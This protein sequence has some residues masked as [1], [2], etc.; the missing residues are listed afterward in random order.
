MPTVVRGEAVE[1]EPEAEH[2]E[3]DANE[4]EASASPRV[5]Q[6][7][8]QDVEGWAALETDLLT[9]AGSARVAKKRAHK[10]DDDAREA[11]CEAASGGEE[12]CGAEPPW[13][14]A[15]PE[16]NRVRWYVVL[17]RDGALVASEP[18]FV[19]G[20]DD[21]GGGDI[22][23][24]QRFEVRDGGILSLEIYYEWYEQSDDPDIED[25]SIHT[26][27]RSVCEL[28]IELETLKVLRAGDEC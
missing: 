21:C 1:S 12:P 7:G 18:V 3:P 10:T 23:A 22:T 20:V 15:I 26:Q 24:L 27:V 11:L 16:Q 28:E 8:P 2:A 6:P 19:N 9:K 13:V 25:C 14:V 5:R 17:V 4:E